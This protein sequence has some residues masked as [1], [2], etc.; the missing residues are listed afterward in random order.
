MGHLR[1]THR[2]VLVRVWF[3]EEP[4]PLC[5]HPERVDKA[6]NISADFTPHQMA[7]AEDATF[8]PAAADQPGCNLRQRHAN[9][10]E[11]QCDACSAC[12]DTCNAVDCSTC[13]TKRSELA[14]KEQRKAQGM[15][16]N[17]PSFTSCQVQRHNT[18]G[19][20][21]FTA[22]GVVYN[23]TGFGKKHPG[24]DAAITR[25]AGSETSRDFD[26]HSKSGQKLWDDYRVGVQKRC[27][28]NDPDDG[29]CLVS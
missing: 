13:A 17:G 28:R 29:G 25:R 26:F 14:E 18:V 21:W 1:C 5:K 2:Q 22:H 10:A 23:G 9:N 19:D 20:C 27:P 24:G 16:Y 8:L 11:S 12:A 3:K 6:L 4:R 7:H 15:F